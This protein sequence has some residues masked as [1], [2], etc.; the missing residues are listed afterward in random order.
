MEGSPQI[1]DAAQERPWPTHRV[2]SV[3][4]AGPASAMFTRSDRQRPW[5][6]TRHRSCDS[7]EPAR[8]RISK[9]IVSSGSL[10]PST[11]IAH[12]AITTA[13][14]TNSTSSCN[15]RISLARQRRAAPS[16]YRTGWKPCEIVFR[17][18]SLRHHLG[19][20]QTTEIDDPISQPLE[21]AMGELEEARGP[22]SGCGNLRCR[23]WCQS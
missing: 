12:Q 13:V 23:T 10:D 15:A 14:D 4:R 16:G 18:G 6:F 22:G 19:C 21:G 9:S 1:A 8:T 17:S 5:P 3:I 11:P 7:P 2:V 20:R